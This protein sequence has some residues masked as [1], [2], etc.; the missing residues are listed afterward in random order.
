MG[1]QLARKRTGA[2]VRRMMLSPMGLQ[3]SIQRIKNQV[4]EGSGGGGG[5]FHCPMGG[6]RG[7]NGQ[8]APWY[9]LVRSRGTNE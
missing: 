6:N 7:G 3:E 9:P 8:K 1:V 4:S 5:P 2:D